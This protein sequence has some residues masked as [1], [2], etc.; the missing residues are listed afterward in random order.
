VIVS[1]RW[2]FI[3]LKTTKTAG[4][5][6]ELALSPFLGPDDIVTPL[7]PAEEELRSARGGGQPRNHLLPRER[8]TLR[9]HLRR[10]FR[11]PPQ[12]YT[13]HMHA[14]EARAELGAEV[15]DSYF[16]FAVCRNPFDRVL[17]HYHWHFRRWRRRA[18][19]AQTIS[20]FIASG[21]PRILQ[22][23]GWELYT[24]DGRL[25]VDQVYRYEELPAA[26]LDLRARL[27]LPQ[28]L[29]MPRAKSSS[30]SDRR[31]HAEVLSAADRERVAAMFHEE[32]ERFGYRS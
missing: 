20:E 16:K 13:S 3:F 23:H 25:A 15:W 31:S 1:H 7:D 8:W 19:G 29:E 24:I 4:T 9:D 21:R 12:R 6:L 26:L 10:P 28:A 22:T 18:F 32:I 5:S 27:G 17:S 11:G 14:T 2:K 30:R